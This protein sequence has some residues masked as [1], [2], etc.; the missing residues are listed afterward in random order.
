MFYCFL[1]SF[2]LAL[3]FLALLFLVLLLLD[4]CF[5]L[6]CFLAFVVCCLFFRMMLR[7]YF[8][9][10]EIIEIIEFIAFGTQKNT[11]LADLCR[12][13]CFAI[14]PSCFLSSCFLQSC[15]HPQ[16]NSIINSVYSPS[17]ESNFKSPPC[18]FKISY[19]KD[20]PRPVPC[21]VGFVVKNG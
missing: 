18:A 16:G 11:D 4:S 2:V 17:L 5:L 14:L 8:E 13:F 19:T 15:Y 3:S 20:N 12:F 21:P 6:S 1:Y 10:I 7:D 9:L